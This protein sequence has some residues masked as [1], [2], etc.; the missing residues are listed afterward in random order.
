MQSVTSNAVAQ[1][2]NG[3]EVTESGYADPNY[4]QNG[5][6]TKYA[7]GIIVEDFLIS[8]SSAAFT[9]RGSLYISDKSSNIP[10]ALKAKTQ[11]IV[12]NAS[13]KSVYSSGKNGVWVACTNEGSDSN[14]KVYY[15]L[16]SHSSGNITNII[17]RFHIVGWW[18]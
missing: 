5:W 16:V 9:A 7:C 13:V 14:T 3:M 10:V 11:P 15:Q 1:A 8:H 4:P 18:K 2:F 12:A 6:Y 17:V